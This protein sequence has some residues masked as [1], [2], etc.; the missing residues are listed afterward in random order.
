MV[1][2][3]LRALK[4]QKDSVVDRF[5][6]RSIIPSYFA[7]FV[8]LFLVA[9]EPF[10]TA[11]GFTVAFGDMPALVLTGLAWPL[12]VTLRERDR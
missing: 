10:W 2:L 9:Q 3:A 7:S 1:A 4:K 6:L 11:V 5:F 8:L 12:L